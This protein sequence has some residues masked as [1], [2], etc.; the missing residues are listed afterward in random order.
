VAVDE[1]YDMRVVQ[2]AEDRNL[3]NEVVLELLVEL[4]HVDRLDSH[5]L[6]LLLL[7]VSCDSSE[8]ASEHESRTMWMPRYTSAKLPLP[9]WSIRLNLPMIC[10]AA[11]DD[12][13]DAP[14][15]RGA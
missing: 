6:A 4:V 8:V 7:S 10:S 5:R 9:M 1:G 14:E 12:D 13:G 2:A 3:G 15:R 11:A